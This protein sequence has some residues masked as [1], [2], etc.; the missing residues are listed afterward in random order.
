MRRENRKFNV[1]YKNIEFYRYITHV[2]DDISLLSLAIELNMSVRLYRCLE[3]TPINCLSKIVS[4]PDEKAKRIRNLGRISF[5]ELK[6]IQKSCN[7]LKDMRNLL[8]DYI[9][10][11]TSNEFFEDTFEEEF[12][13]DEEEVK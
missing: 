9:N 4:L 5:N 3:R 6:D 2:I 11:H 12:F 10:Q 8:Q 1:N 13:E 7:E